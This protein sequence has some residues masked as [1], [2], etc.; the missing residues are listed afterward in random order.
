MQNFLAASFWIGVG[1]WV[2]ATLTSACAAAIQLLAIRSVAIP[3]EGIALT[4][5]AVQG[6]GHHE[7]LLFLRTD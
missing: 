3:Y 7:R 2:L 4:V 5:K 1:S 6:D